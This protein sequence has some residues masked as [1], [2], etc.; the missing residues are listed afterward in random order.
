MQSCIRLYD[1][2]TRSRPPRSIGS[3]PGQLQQLYNLWRRD[4]IVLIIRAHGT[5]SRVIICASIWYIYTSFCVCCVCVCVDMCTPICHSKTGMANAWMRKDGASNHRLAIGCK[6]DFEKHTL[7]SYA[8][9]W[10][11]D[12]SNCSWSSLY[13]CEVTRV[14]ISR[15][16]YLPASLPPTAAWRR[17]L[18]V[19]TAQGNA[20]MVFIHIRKIK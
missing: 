1:E 12:I 9:L 2:V 17:K 16:P 6:R 10:C 20:V 15:Q 3:S 7:T 13:N 19:H 5:L 11:G 14:T 18:C 8:I 4:K